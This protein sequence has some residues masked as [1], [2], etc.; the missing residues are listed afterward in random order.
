MRSAITIFILMFTTPVVAADGVIV[1]DGIGAFV[2]G[3]A[4]IG[5]GLFLRSFLS[6]KAENLATKQD[7]QN[8]THLQ[9][10]VKSEFDQLLERQRAAGQ[11]RLAVAERRFEK[12]QEAH[13]LW[14]RLVGNVY[15]PNIGDIIVECN[16]WWLENSLYLDPDARLAF[17][18]SYHCAADHMGLLEGERNE[19]NRQLIQENWRII[20]DAGPKIADAVNLPRLDVF[21]IQ[22]PG[23]PEPVAIPDEG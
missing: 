23:E 15:T 16:K 21:E 6:K 7:I 10:E 22:A 18:R 14:L 19:D 11:L 8:I 20:N 3:A 4:I 5:T 1:I 12:H 13:T 17:K 9:E 2:V